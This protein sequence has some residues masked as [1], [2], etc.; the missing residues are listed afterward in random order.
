MA[1][2][3]EEQARLTV[4]PEVVIGRPAKSAA[5]RPTLPEA[6]TQPA[7]TSSTSFGS[8]F[9]RATAWRIASPKIFT[10]EVLLKPPRCDLARPVRAYET[11]TASRMEK[12]LRFEQWLWLS[13]YDDLR[14]RTSARTPRSK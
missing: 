12:L 2:R 14:R 5:A 13:A 3:P 11:M 4:T 1:L 8:T 6:A 7:T 9:E 10:F